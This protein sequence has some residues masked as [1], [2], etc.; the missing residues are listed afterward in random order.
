MISNEITSTHSTD[1]PDEAIITSV[2][3]QQTKHQFSISSFKEYLAYE[4]GIAIEAPPPWVARALVGTLS[5][6]VFGTIIWS[7]VSK[8][9]VVAT[10]SGELIP[11][12]RVTPIQALGGGLLQEIKVKEGDYVKKGD[13][14]VKLN[15]TLSN[16]EF[17]RLRALV[18]LKR[19]QLT[20]LEAERSGQSQTSSPLQNELLSERA[21]E[22]RARVNRQR[23]VVKAAQAALR[24]VQIHLSLADTRRQ[25]LGMLFHNG[26]IPRMDYLEAQTEFAS[27]QEEYVAKQQEIAQ[28]TEE[29]KQ[30]EATQRSEILTQLTQ[31]QQELASLEGQLA[32]AKEQRDRDTIPAPVS[33]TV[34]NVKIAKTGATLQP[35][36]ELLSIAPE[37]EEL[38]VE[39]KVLN[40]DIGF[41]KPGMPVKVKLE[42]FP[43]QEFGILSGTV[44]RV[45]ANSVSHP[46]EGLVFPAR[47][48]LK[49]HSVRVRGQEVPLAPGMAVT[50]EIV[51][52]QRTVLSFILEPIT[53][54]L[55]NAFSVR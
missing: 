48:R 1:E 55:D 45:S 16:A 52:R 13:S 14:L 5:L 2:Q 19:E 23:S 50:A 8:V 27:L 11:S 35:G 33:G 38:I 36:E 7:A 46:Q 4:L 18:Q 54:S 44:E 30:L 24:R 9:D 20:R 51:T 10:A 31:E 12:S 34:Y 47:I 29:L 37:G 17:Q 39:A 49:Q 28:A 15:P 6:L 25:S 40:R 42:T 32:Q 41:V 3:R 53:A 22:T 26:A 21:K 43:Y